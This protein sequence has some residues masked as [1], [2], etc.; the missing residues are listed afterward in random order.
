MGGCGPQL[1]GY[2]GLQT[3]GYLPFSYAAPTSYPPAVRQPA[4][5][6]PPREPA[7]AQGP[8]RHYTRC[9]DYRLPE[10]MASGWRSAAR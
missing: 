6:E 3:P 2:Y 1:G 4:V 9:W 7:V 8:I 5:T 10:D